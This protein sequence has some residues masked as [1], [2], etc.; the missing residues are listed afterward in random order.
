MCSSPKC[1]SGQIHVGG[2]GHPIMTCKACS[3]RT[4][5]VHKIPWHKG[6]SCHDYDMLH[7]G[8]EEQEVASLYYLSKSS[9]VCPNPVCGLHVQKV[10]GCDHIYYSLLFIHFYKQHAENI[11]VPITTSSFAGF[12]LPLTM[13]LEVKVTQHM[14]QIANTTVA[15]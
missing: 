4:C 12:V 5:F 1:N 2:P 14:Q 9:K 13:I 15:D 8:S 10:D 3:Y 11:Q 6:L 7:K